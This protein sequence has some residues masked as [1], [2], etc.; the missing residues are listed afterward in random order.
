MKARAWG[1]KARKG[2]GG[3]DLNGGRTEGEREE[4]RGDLNGGKVGEG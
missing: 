4:V 3:R 1:V 2:E